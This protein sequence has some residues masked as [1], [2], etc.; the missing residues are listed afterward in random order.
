MTIDTLK[1][2][3]Q[4]IDAA[5]IRTF[6]KGHIEVLFY[7]LKHL[8]DLTFNAITQELIDM[9]SGHPKSLTG[10]YRARARQMSE[11]KKR[12]YFQ[13]KNLENEIM[14]HSRA[15]GEYYRMVRRTLGK[16]KISTVPTWR[17][18]WTSINLAWGSAKTEEKRIEAVNAGNRWLD[19]IGIARVA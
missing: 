13:D 16:L 15:C 6:K 18:F 2:G 7:E 11:D 12:A 10:F 1:S 4:R 8:E 5:G 9:Q 19:E 3:L 17:E 14:K